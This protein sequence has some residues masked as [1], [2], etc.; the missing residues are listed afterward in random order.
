MITIYASPFAI[1]EELWYHVRKL[2]MMKRTIALTAFAGTAFFANAQTAKD[3]WLVG[4]SLE[5]TS[6]TQKE[7]GTAGGSTTT[8]QFTPDFGYFFINN[9]AAGLDLNL[10]SS[11]SSAGGGFSSTTTLFT[12]GPL[13]RYYFYTAGNVKLFV[14]GDAQWGNTKFNFS[15]GG[16]S[17]NSP[18][19][20]LSIYEGKFGTAIFLDRNVGLEFTLGYQSLIEKD[21]SVTPSE[22]ITTSA[23][24]IGLGFQIYLGPGKMKGGSH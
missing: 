5:F 2:T 14:H 3:S 4:G 22:N 12:A 7:A 16:V 9:L 10:A 1:F 23:F 24:N 11:H 21:N 17:Q 20:P 18:G 6:S 19:V 8:I 15:G 13:V